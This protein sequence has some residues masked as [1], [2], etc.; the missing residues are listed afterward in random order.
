MSA[1]TRLWLKIC[2]ITSGAD[3]ELCIDA[4]ADAIGINL[5]ESSKRR[6]DEATAKLIADAA[7]GRIELVG[8]VADRSRAEL[9]RLRTELG[10]DWLQLHGAEP[11]ELLEGLPF[12]F[13][14]AAIVETADVARAASYPGERL[15][16]DSRSGGSGV[17]FD[18]RW[19]E[20]LA[21]ARRVI[22]AGG[23]TPENVARAIGVVRPYGVDV[24]SG[25]ERPGAPRQKDPDLV[26]A[27]VT[28]ARA[29]QPWL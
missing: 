25:V 18:W 23:I 14:A 15:L 13:K 22:L 6:V 2:G 21:R 1:V 20:E 5:V 29:A 8:V 19:A 11:P 28:A 24:A 27:F 17:P 9:L 16:L 7:R 12:A 26:R 10:L 4:G 3:A